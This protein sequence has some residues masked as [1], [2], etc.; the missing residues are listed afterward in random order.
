MQLTAPVQRALNEQVG[1][2]FYAAYLYL[3]MSCWFAERNLDGF[4]KWMRIQAQ[5]ERDH[6]M[7]ILGYLEDRKGHVE[8]GAIAQPKVAWKT[9]L[10][11]FE[12]AARHEAQVSSSLKALYERAGKDKDYATQV[13]LQWFLTEQVEEEKTSTAIV[14]R[15]RLF[16]DT[17]S[18]LMMLDRQLG[19]RGGEKG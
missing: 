18:G 7:R 15:L 17:P 6:A 2:E 9:P 19:E 5:E 14:E 12:A 4:A 1:K 3:A 13:M 16:G 8:L 10:G 11:V